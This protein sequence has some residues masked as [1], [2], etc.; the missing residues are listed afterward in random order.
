MTNFYSPLSIKI[1]L[2]LLKFERN[3]I[4]ICYKLYT[5]LL[6]LPPFCF[7][8]SREMASE[9]V[10]NREANK[11]LQP[12]FKNRSFQQKFRQTSTTGKK[13]TWRSLKQVLAQERSLPWPTTIKHCM[14]RV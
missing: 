6:Y 7:R 3:C 8:K 9:E 11:K 4:L 5:R 2:D 12:I 1:L 13:R 14:H 10:Y